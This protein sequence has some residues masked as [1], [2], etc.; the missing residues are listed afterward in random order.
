AGYVQEKSPTLLQP[1]VPM[2][3]SLISFHWGEEASRYPSDEGL[4]RAAA[5][6]RRVGRVFEA[7]PAIK[8]V[9]RTDGGPRRLG[10]PYEMHE[11]RVIPMATDRVVKHE[12]NGDPDVAE[13]QEWLAGLDG[14]WQ[15]AGPD[16]AR[17]VLTEL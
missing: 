4:S 14:V 16:R 1:V 11:L 8:R 6:S 10:P 12:V 13:T 17:F 5:P 3:H 2:A 9:L 15:T 7:H